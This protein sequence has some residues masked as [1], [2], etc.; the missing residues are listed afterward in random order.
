MVIL[1]FQGMARLDIGTEFAGYRIDQLI[2][3]GGMAL[4]YRATQL[5]HTGK[6]VALKIIAPEHSEDPEFRERF[7]REARLAASIEHPNVIPINEAR[8]S[9]GLLFLSMMYVDGTDLHE[10][11]ARG[12]ALPPDRAAR[13]LVP[14]AEALDEAHVRGLVHRDVKPGNILIREHPRE[15]VYLA[16]FGIARSSEYSGIT[17]STKV[18]GTLDYMAPEQLEG[19]LDSRSDI[20]ALGCVLYEALTGRV[21][22]PR[23]TPAAQ[24]W[25]HLQDKPTAVRELVK[26]IP[27]EFEEVLARSMA[28]DPADRYRTAGEMANAL[29][30]AGSAVATP[31]EETVV[32]EKR[33]PL[34]PPPPPPPRP[35]PKTETDLEPPAR[36]GRRPVI[37]VGVGAV[38]VLGAA[39][40]I[41]A[42]GGGDGGTTTTTTTPPTTIT[43]PPVT[44][45]GGT[46]TFGGST[47]SKPVSSTDADE[48]VD[49]FMTAYHDRDVDEMYKALN[50]NVALTQGNGKR[51][52]GFGPVINYYRDTFT[53]MTGDPVA[54]LTDRSTVV[55]PD[56]D[57]ATVTATWHD[58]PQLPGYPVKFHVTHTNDLPEL[59]VID[60]SS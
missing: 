52:N 60:Y 51:Y 57:G 35:K 27:E 2:G 6:T 29:L 36:R 45:D 7:I 48:T 10:L 19:K 15:R 33:A 14:V 25:A 3:R 41:A 40:A 47:A 18:V 13:L 1:G 54:S 32:D 34:P 39:A 49:R 53:G 20:Y 44:T 42:G 38:A 59:D 17:G 23:D 12:G 31:T 21:P 28:K 56:G 4:V 22:F 5:D 55:D 50:I 30:E 16:D 8:E 58:L 37:L 24:M 26:G 43:E 11:I 46:T 9:D